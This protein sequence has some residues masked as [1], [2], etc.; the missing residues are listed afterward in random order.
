MSHF[1]LFLVFFS[2]FCGYW[3]LVHSF[4]LKDGYPRSKYSKKRD[5]PSVDVVDGVSTEEYPKSLFVEKDFAMHYECGAQTA[6]NHPWIA[7]I[8]HTDPSGNPKKKTLSKGVLIGPQ[9]V[10]TTVSS[11]H[12]SHPF[13]VV[14][15]V[16]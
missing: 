14:S 12:N 5:D 4:D 6:E 10:L 15:G 3:M 16:R 7:V 13:W 1:T 2:I 8:E 9:H 11:I